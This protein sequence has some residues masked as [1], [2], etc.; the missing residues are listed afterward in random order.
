MPSSPPIA[1]PSKVAAA[2]KDRITVPPDNRR[3][4]TSRP[5][6]S[7]PSSAVEEDDSNGPP[8]KSTGAFGATKGPTP[9][10]MST[11][12]VRTAPHRAPAFE[13]TQRG[14]RNQGRLLA[15][16]PDFADSAGGSGSAMVTSPAMRHLLSTAALPGSRRHRR[17]R[18]TA[19]KTPP[20]AAQ[21][22]E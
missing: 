1:T 16:E 9:T 10:R 18:S 2:D 15:C 14:W 7:A 21:W 13:K 6:I 4:S 11:E 17:S 12:A 20:A 22:P 19:R 3:D 5:R 8:T